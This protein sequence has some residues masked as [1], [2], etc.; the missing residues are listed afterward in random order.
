MVGRKLPTFS[1]FSP[2]ETVP[3]VLPRYAFARESTYLK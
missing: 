1:N 2:L 3:G